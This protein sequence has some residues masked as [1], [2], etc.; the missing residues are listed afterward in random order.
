MVASRDQARSVRVELDS[1][2]VPHRQLLLGIAP[3][4]AAL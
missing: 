4:G 2:L 3:I 1:V